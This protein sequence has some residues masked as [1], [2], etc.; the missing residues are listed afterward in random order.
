MLD[1]LDDRLRLML[2]LR[3]RLAGQAPQTLVEVE[4]IRRGTAN[5]SV[6]WRRGR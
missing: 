1:S 4:E 6:S 5:G 2:Q 3:F